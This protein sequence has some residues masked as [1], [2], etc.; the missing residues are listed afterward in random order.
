MLKSTTSTIREGICVGATTTILV[1]DIASNTIAILLLMIQTIVSESP[2]ERDVAKPSIYGCSPRFPPPPALV[3]VSYTHLRAH[4]TPEHLVCRLLLEK[5]KTY[6]Y[7][8]YINLIST[9]QNT[10]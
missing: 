2:T 4:E 6:I 1:P 5:K 8:T 10:N 7:I 3:A 9:L